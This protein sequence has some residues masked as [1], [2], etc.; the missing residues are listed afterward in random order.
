MDPPDDLED[1]AGDSPPRESRGSPNLT[2]N[3]VIDFS[4]GWSFSDNYGSSDPAATGRDLQKIATIN[5]R[6]ASGQNVTVQD[7]SGNT[8]TLRPS[9]WTTFTDGRMDI[10]IGGFIP[11]APNNVAS[12]KIGR[13]VPLLQPIGK[14]NVVYFG[15]NLDDSQKA[16][17]ISQA[18]AAIA[19]LMKSPTFANAFNQVL[20]EGN[21]GLAINPVGYA[22][23]GTVLGNNIVFGTGAGRLDNGTIIYAAYNIAHEIGHTNENNKNSPYFVKDGTTIAAA[24]LF[25]TV[26]APN[27][28]EYYAYHFAEQVAREI[29]EI[30]NVNI[31]SQ[32]SYAD[33]GGL[34]GDIGLIPSNK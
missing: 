10:S 3:G 22:K 27:S 13:F 8:Y 17:V 23:G 18:K 15:G 26:Q 24:E 7:A 19:L 20:N 2:N 29:R 34:I 12:G 1:Q 4:G 21:H 14:G 11:L 33:V 6:L 16:V 5:A 28:S 31:G 32:S 30:A 9:D 25:A